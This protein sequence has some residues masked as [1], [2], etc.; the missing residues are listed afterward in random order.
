MRQTNMKCAGYGT[1]L[2]C[3][4]RCMTKMR[5]IFTVSCNIFVRWLTT[6]VITSLTKV[7]NPQQLSNGCRSRCR[8][9]NILSHQKTELD[10]WCY[11]RRVHRSTTTAEE[12]VNGSSQYEKKPIDLER[13]KRYLTLYGNM[14]IPVNWGLSDCAAEEQLAKKWLK[15]M[16]N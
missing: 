3:R 4:H 16:E 12:I 9:L 8:H 7:F 6:T 11:L 14:S 2:F 13:L 15:M 10:F 5:G 1:N